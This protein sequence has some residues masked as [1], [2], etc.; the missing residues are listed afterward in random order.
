MAITNFRLR[1]RRPLGLS[2]REGAKIVRKAEA[3]VWKAEE[4]YFND[5]I[6]EGMARRIDRG[7]ADYAAGIQAGREDLP[8]PPGVSDDWA[9][10][11]RAGRRNSRRRRKPKPLD[12]DGH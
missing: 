11:Y 6:I 8:F 1:R 5:L 7:M 9:R 12:V 2:E 4:D 10:G 3:A